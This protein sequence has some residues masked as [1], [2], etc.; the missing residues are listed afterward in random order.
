MKTIQR[1]TIWLAVFSL[2]LENLGFPLG[3]REIKIWMLAA[4]LGGLL[5][6]VNVYRKKNFNWKD[7]NM[8][9]IGIGFLLVSLPGI[10]LYSP[11]PSYAFQQWVVLGIIL[12]LGI[13]FERFS[14]NYPKDIYTALFISFVLTCIAAIYQNVAFELGLP[15]GEVMAAR[16]NAFFPEPDWLGIYLVITL[17][18]WLPLLDS[19]LKK[20]LKYIPAFLKKKGVAEAL[21]F[22]G[23]VVVIISV[24][25][26]SWLAVIAEVGVI[27]FFLAYTRYRETRKLKTFL[28]EGW[29]YGGKV[30]VLFLI[31]LIS[32]SVLNLTRFDLADRFRSI[33]FQEHV[34]TLAFNPD[35]GEKFK[36]DL[37]EKEKYESRGYKII[38]E[39]VGD[40]NVESREDKALSSWDYI[41]KH[42][43]V[44]N[45]L[46]IIL[47][48]T[49]F[50]H[51]ANNLFLEWWASAGLLG[52][53]V[54][55]FTL[56]C[57]GWKGWQLLKNNTIV[58]LV[59][60]AG[61]AGF[62]IVNLFN[63]TIFLPIAWFFWG[64]AFSWYV[65]NKKL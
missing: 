62:I 52:I 22:L 58:G 39:Y 15:H 4:F 31:S 63:A 49:N 3:G 24:A 16:P 33:F 48:S 5:V 21:V 26:A 23:M 12:V 47:I 20:S 34:V 36:I 42:P 40:E 27:K 50:E 55:L 54:L 19:K 43:V 10:V 29:K 18:F 64:W 2:A 11:L 9:L 53:A 56:S 59:I 44:G 30:L 61:L 46:G 65:Y 8:M 51:N 37:E 14:K 45:G 57:I 17:A 41:K 13:F 25:R 38:E 7:S 35:T 32:I 1:L 6:L 28:L 60:L